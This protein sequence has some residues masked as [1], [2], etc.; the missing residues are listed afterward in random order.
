MP[1]LC[2]NPVRPAL[3][4][5]R[6][7]SI[8]YDFL[9]KDPTNMHKLQGCFILTPLPLLIMFL[10]G[11]LR[12]PYPRRP[13]YKSRSCMNPPLSCMLTSPLHLSIDNLQARYRPCSHKWQHGLYLVYFIFQFPLLKYELFLRDNDI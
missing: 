6:K 9:N 7:M 2:S 11:W 8:Y 5:N 1:E 3:A 12:T 10:N 4:Q 13:N